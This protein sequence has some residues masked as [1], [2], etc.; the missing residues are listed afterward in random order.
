MAA[1]KHGRWQSWPLITRLAANDY[2]LHLAQAKVLVQV[3]VKAD[4]IFAIDLVW[5]EH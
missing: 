2:N 3:E 5:Y 1:D 4:S